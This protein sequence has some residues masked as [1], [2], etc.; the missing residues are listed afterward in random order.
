MSAPALELPSAGRHD[1]GNSSC[2][3]YKVEVRS[4][5]TEPTVISLSDP[6]KP[7]FVIDNYWREWPVGRENPEALVRVPVCSWDA[8]ALRYGLLSYTAAMTHAW[9]LVASLEAG[10]G[11]AFGS[12]GIEIRLVEVRLNI[13]YATEELGV[14]SIDRRGDAVGPRVPRAT[15][16]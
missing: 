13:T 8:D 12:L 7:P 15:A 3:Y 5:L 4:S 2:T 14:L 11:G 6:R 10:I 9:G 16:E 1:S